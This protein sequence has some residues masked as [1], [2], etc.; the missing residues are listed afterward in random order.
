MALWSYN[1]SPEALELDDKIGKF[2]TIIGVPSAF[3]LHGY[4]GFIFGSIKAN[5]WWSSPLMP[6]IFIFSAMVSGIA[7]VMLIYMIVSWLRKVVIDMNC[8][9]TIGRY[10]LYAFIIDFSLETLDLIHRFYESNEAFGALAML[11][12]GKLH[13]SLLIVQIALGTLVP[14]TLLSI[15]QLIKVKP[16]IRKPMYFSAGMLT[17]IG[18][19]AMRWNVVIGGQLFSKSFR[20]FTTYKLELIGKE[21][22]MTAAA[23]II[24]PVIILAVLIYLFPPFAKET[25][26]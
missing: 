1:I 12:S 26:E 9:D 2:V 14:I 17:L 23:L 10:L 21:G 6:V 8:L 7:L 3:L 13:I 20:G 24:L 25:G 16:E 11:M 15:I 18:I 22:L 19:F 5:P 4:V